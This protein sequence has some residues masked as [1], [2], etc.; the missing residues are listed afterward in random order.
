MT[1]WHLTVELH[2]Y[3][4]AGSGSS[5]GTHLDALCERDNH[6]LPFLSGR[7]LKGLLRHAVQRAEQWQ[8]LDNIP[9]PAG[10]QPDWETMLFGTRSQT[11][12]RFHTLPGL[13]MVDNARLPASEKAWLEQH[14]A[15][16]AYL[17]EEIY[18]TAINENGTAV[19]KSLR[20]M[21]AALP[22]TLTALVNV[23]LTALDPEHRRQQQA[24]IST[25]MSVLLKRV[26]PLIDSV[27]G[28]R[29]RGLGEAVLSLSPYV[30]EPTVQ[31]VQGGRR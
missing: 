13:L 18:S 11:A 21:E 31:P 19:A 25:D 24:A 14:P 16:K 15:Y 27:G 10:P 5:S 7:H 3:W 1:A 26:L 30:S 9:L 29:T 17:F 22:M 4:H 8:W 6:G 12:Q 2:H 23:E 20:G 28:N